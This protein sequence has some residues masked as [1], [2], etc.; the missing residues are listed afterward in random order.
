M[1]EQPDPVPAVGIPEARTAEAEADSG[2]RAE[3]GELVR[4]RDAREL[5]EPYALTV[6]MADRV[7]ERRGGG[8]PRPSQARW[9][10]VVSP[11]RDRP[12]VWPAASR[13]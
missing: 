13:A 2:T 11:P 12:S 5:F 6:E 8:R 10:L 1:P 9:T 7:S 4:R 3:P